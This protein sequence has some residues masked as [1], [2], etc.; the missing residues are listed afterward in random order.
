MSLPGLDEAHHYIIR[1]GRKLADA[2][3]KRDDLFV[4]VR[5]LRRLKWFVGWAVVL[6]LVRYMCWLWLSVGLL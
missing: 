6:W 3:A 4:Q 5:W 1:Q 2:A